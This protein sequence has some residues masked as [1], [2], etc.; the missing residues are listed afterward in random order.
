[1]GADRQEFMRRDRP[2]PWA[3]LFFAASAGFT[4]VALVL[5]LITAVV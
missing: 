2:S 1:M 5:L 3:V 4:G